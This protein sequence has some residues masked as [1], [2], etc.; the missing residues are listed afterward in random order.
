M[1][2]SS[3]C[4]IRVVENL[5]ENQCTDIGGSSD[6][7]ALAESGHWSSYEQLAL[8]FANNFAC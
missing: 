5:F 1:C 4:S 8:F 2:A 3:V 6:N 7:H